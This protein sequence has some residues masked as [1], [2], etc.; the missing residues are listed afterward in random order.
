MA[1]GAITLWTLSLMIALEMISMQ[2]LV[3]KHNQLKRVRSGFSFFPES[4]MLY[5]KQDI[6][7][8]QE[9]YYAL[10]FNCHKNCNLYSLFTGFFF[11][12]L[13]SDSQPFFMFYPTWI[14]TFNLGGVNCNILEEFETDSKWSPGTRAPR[15]LRAHPGTDLAHWAMDNRPAFDFLKSTQKNLRNFAGRRRVLGDISVPS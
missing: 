1:L 8:G 2:L 5:P 12:L 11:T 13:K 10:G 3:Y 6:D 4:Y 9:W 14:L 15:I 7:Q